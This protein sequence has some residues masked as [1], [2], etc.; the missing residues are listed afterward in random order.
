MKNILKEKLKSGKST[1][2]IWITIP[3][4]DITESL[5][6]LPFDWFV[7]DQEH[8][9]LNVE[10]TQVLMQAMKGSVTPLIRVAWNDAVRIKKALDTGAQG[11]IIPWVNN[12]SDAERAVSACMYPPEGI[13]GC[14]PRRTVILDEDYLKTANQEILVMV[15][16]ETEEAVRNAEGILSVKG[17]DAF[18]VGPFDL[19]ASMGIM[20]D[21]GNSKVQDAIEHV[22]TIGKE[23]GVASGLWTGAGKSIKE[24]IN[25]GWQFISVGMD[26][27]VL[28][29]GAEKFLE[30]VHG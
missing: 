15:Q 19:S 20:G 29:K 12:R 18:F 27:N 16:I 10:R 6:T 22:L 17:V 11:I 28:I 9:V 30:E 3:H 1:L 13:R 23:Q 25:E 21:I 4:P 5:S 26:I 24:R 8:S 14:A 7:F 2:G